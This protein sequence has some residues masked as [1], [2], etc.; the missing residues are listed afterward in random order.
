M[1]TPEELIALADSLKGVLRDEQIERIHR[2][3]VKMPEDKRAELHATLEK[4]QTKHVEKMKGELDTRQAMQGLYE[5]KQK[6]KTT[7]A[8]HDAEEQEHLESEAEAERLLNELNQ[9]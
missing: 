5:A 8:L 6:Q 3:A 2:I 7:Q 4:L 1:P 9:L